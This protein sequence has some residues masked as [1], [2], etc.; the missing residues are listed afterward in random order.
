MI[1]YYVHHQG[2]GHWQRACAFARALRTPC[3]LLGTFDE[4][5]LREAPCPCVPLPDDRIGPEFG[6]ID[7]EATRPASLHYAPLDH[8]GVRARMGRI[9]EWVV[10]HDPALMIVDVSVEVALLA[11]LLSV[12]TLVVHGSAAPAERLTLTPRELL[13][14]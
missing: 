3:T 5:D 6:A 1:G 7:G 4:V 8:P 13:V 12:P 14:L 10:A 11:R 9:A 2:V